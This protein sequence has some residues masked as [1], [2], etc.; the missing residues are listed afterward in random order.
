[1]QAGVVATNLFQKENQNMKSA[2]FI[3]VISIFLALNSPAFAEG[4]SSSGDKK[5]S[6]SSGEF[7]R[8]EKMREVKLAD[9]KQKLVEFCNL[10]KPFSIT[11]SSS[12]AIE[13]NYTYCCHKK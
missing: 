13:T 11:G 9:L 4:E 12:L 6:D 2:I 1:M 3:S 7:F 5:S 10:D 8:C